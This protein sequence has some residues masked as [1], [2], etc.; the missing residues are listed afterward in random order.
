MEAEPWEHR[1]GIPAADIVEN[2][3]L[4]G[5]EF[6]DGHFYLTGGVSDGDNV[7]YVLN[8]EGELVRQFNQ[9]ADS[10]Y[11]YRDLAYDG[12][13]LWGVDGAVVHGF[14][15]EGE[16][17]V[18]LNSPLNGIRGITWDPENELL[19]MCGITTRVFAIDRNGEVVRELDRFGDLRTYGLA[20]YPDASDGFY[21]RLF[22]SNG[23]FNR[24]IFKANPETGD[25]EFIT[26]PDIEGSAG[27]ATVNRRWDPFSW[28]L[29][30]V[31]NSPDRIEIWHID[32]PTGWVD[33]NPTEGVVEPDEETEIIITLDTRDFPVNIEFTA[34]LVF[35][36]D[37]VGGETIIPV[38]LIA[39][40]E[41]GVSERI[42]DLPFGWN[43]VSVN[44]VPE[45]PDVVA[46]TV[47]LV[48]NDLLE[49][50][51]NGA[52]Q[53]YS[54]AFNFNNIPG[55]MVDQGYLMKTADDCQLTITGETV[56]PDLRIELHRGWQMIAYYPRVPVEAT[57]ALSGI[58]E[59]LEM[60]K[61]GAGH[62]YSPAFGFSNI[63]DMREG[64][65]YLVKVTEDVDL[66]Y[67]V[68][69][70]N[71]IGMHFPFVQNPVLTPTLEPTSENMSLLLL[72]ENPQVSDNF[73]VKVYA[74]DKLVGSG[75]LGNE[76][77][78]VAVWGDDPTTEIIDGAEK[79]QAL[80]IEL[81][82]SQD[83]NREYSFSTISGAGEYSK[84]SLWIVDVDSE[85]SP[86]EFGIVETYPNPFNSMTRLSFNIFE[87][88]EVNLSVLDLK[89]R[90]IKTIITEHLQAGTHSVMV[91]GDDLASGIYI[92]RLNTK[93]R[94]YRKKLILIK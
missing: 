3:R 1:A 39:S 63:G 62:F 13:L 16:L 57:V 5:V 30:G 32:A 25:Y 74:G 21:L 58:V 73:D 67:I 85:M 77:C 75:F 59:S 23:D 24:Q 54:P 41:G 10:R 47:E 72:S 6:V 35:T 42:L 64:Q 45:E 71:F 80:R 56:A 26:E 15:L 48:E 22:C 7:I 86:M 83:N 61:D 12:D 55:W 19:W 9:F 28:V 84:N 92:G 52:G 46:L 20:W 50:M 79:G 8:P 66:Q 91:N 69:E 36:H 90:L 11:G 2:S 27:A 37:G 44:V 18:E 43:M 65:G 34:D 88:G 94:T 53:F 40:E 29:I 14:T 17:E 51:K 31:T 49:I 78:G 82:S 81:C 93:G 68:P 38:S 89:G 76:Q 4:G 33:I 87:S 60:A 70:G